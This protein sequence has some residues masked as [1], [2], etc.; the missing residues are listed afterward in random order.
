ML[1]PGDDRPVTGLP[2]FR[3]IYRR[4]AGRRLLLASDGD[5]EQQEESRGE[6]PNLELHAG[7]LPL[8]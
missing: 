1:A 6:E 5:E 2:R 7:R 3:N 8:I 4:R